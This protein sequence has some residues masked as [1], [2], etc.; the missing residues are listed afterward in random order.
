[1][2]IY[3]FKGVPA[4]TNFQIPFNLNEKALNKWLASL[5]NNPDAEKSHQILLAIQAI[6]RETKLAIAK[7]L[8]LLKTIYHQIPIILDSLKQ[9]ILK[10]SLPLS[11]KEQNNIE[12]IV[13]IYAELAN[14]FAS[15]ITKKS[16]RDNAQ[17]LFY[18]LQSLVSVYL[19]ISEVYQ[20]PFPKFWKQSYF[21]YG[22]ASKLEIQ[23]LNIKQD[24]F[25]NDTI[26]KAFKHLLALYHC[27]PE[28]FRPRDILTV[29]TCLEKHTSLML[30]K[31]NITG[32]NASRY[33]GFDLNSDTPPTA[34]VRF[35]KT[36]KSSLYFFSA[37]PSATAIYKNA[38]E[39]AAGT[40]FLKL[41]NQESIRQ[42]AKTLS[43]SQKRQFTRFNEQQFKSGIIGLQ[44][45][46]DKLANTSTLT[47]TK[48]P[49]TQATI[50]RYDP[51]PTKN[52]KSSD[53]EL[54]PAG[55]EALDVLKHTVT[56]GQ[57]ITEKQKQLNQTKKVFNANSNIYSHDQDIWQGTASLDQ[58]EL[59]ENNELELDISDNSI[60]GYKIIFDT[61]ENTSRVQIGDII[62]IKNNTS[63]EVGIIRRILQL[64]GHKLQLGIKLLSLE[65]EIAY[66]TLPNHK[67]VYA[68]ALF[69]PSIKELNFQSSIIFN[70]SRFHSESIITLHR[71]DQKNFSCHL[72]KPIHIS[73]AAVHYKTNQLKPCE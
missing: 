65:S 6:N 28:Q 69:L 11:A 60:N 38:D 29:S 8:I 62:G 2:E 71:T 73:Y 55:Y 36:V 10:S 23:D 67:S 39:E 22:I 30:I 16:S 15:C 24:K 20:Q 72:S 33:S 9:S 64:T 12:H 43:L 4:T 17:T 46:I 35:E 5:D 25:H 61:N 32:N 19:H 59:S 41:I 52:W 47:P 7:N 34:L 49:T 53:L 68:W 26:N 57:F 45:I 14:G 70:D 54:V 58:Q 51:R 63:I 21:F 37:Y 42:A 66:I 40:G 13:W 44:N 48:T 27:G 1:M 18:G 31:Q 3:K 56:Q 50:N